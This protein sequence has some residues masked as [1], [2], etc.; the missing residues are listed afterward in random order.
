MCRCWCTGCAWRNKHWWKNSVTTIALTNAKWAPSGRELSEVGRHDD[1]VLLSGFGERG[2]ELHRGGSG[3]L[4]QP[5]SGGRP[6]V[7]SYNAAG[8]CVAAGVR[9]LLSTAAGDGRSVV[10]EDHPIRGHLEYSDFAA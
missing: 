7:L 10:G 6:V 4:A 8:R 5:V 9:A 1:D 3:V 2:G